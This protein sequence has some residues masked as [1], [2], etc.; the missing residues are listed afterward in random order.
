MDGPSSWQ[1][2]TQRASFA[3]NLTASQ[4]QSYSLGAWI[5]STDWLDMTAYN[6]VPTYTLSGPSPTTSGGPNSTS[7]VPTS[8]S[9]AS[10]NA[11]PDSGSVPPT[12]AVLVSQNGQMNGSFSNITAALA[13][14]PNDNTNQT[15]FIYSGTYTEQVPTINRPGALRILGYTTAAPGSSYQNNTVTITFS[16]GLSVS[17]LPVGHS[18]AETAT[19]QTASNRISWY[20]I[21]MINSD[22]LDGL[23][24]NY[25]TLAA[26]IYGNDIGFYAVSMIGWQDTLLTGATNGYQYYES[27]YIE[28]A[29]DFIWGYSKAYFKGCTIAAKRASSSMT[30]QSRA[31]ASAVGGYIFDQCLFTTAASATVDLTQAV[32]LGRPYSAYAL[33]VVKNSYLDTCI[34]P[35]GWKVWSA[36][37]PRTDHI[38]FAEYANQGPGAWQDNVAARQAFQ[39]CTLLTSDT[40]S[41]ATVMDSTSWIDMTYFNTIVTPAPLAPTTGSGSTV[42]VSGNSTYDGTIPPNGAIIVSQTPING[43]TT[44]NTIQGALNA[45]PASSKTNATIFIYPG[46]YTEHLVVNKSGTTIFQGYS[47]S[48]NNYANNQVTITFSYGVNTQSNESNSDSATVYATGNYFYA[49]NINFR[50]DNGTQQDIASLGFAVKSSKYAL[51]YSCQVYGNQDT[52]LIN[53]FLFA[54]KSYIEGNIDFIWGSGSGYFLNSTIAANED[55]INITADK[56]TTN[57]TQAGFVF[58]QCTIVPAAGK[59]GFTSVGLGRPWNDLARV[60]YIDCYLSSMIE[61]AGWN[62]WSKSTPQ[63]DQVTY[64]EYHNYGPGAAVCGRANFSQQ[65]T[66]SSV[67]QFQLGNFFTTTSWIDYSR[68]DV[69]PF[70]VGIGSAPLPCATVS[71]SS[72]IILPTS[73]SSAST[74]TLSST[75]SSSLPPTTILL[76]KTVTDKETLFTTFTSADITST[77]TSMVTE[78]H[79][80][81]VTPAVMTKTTTDKASTTVFFTTT[82]AAKTS[83]IVSTTVVSM[84]STVTPLPSTIT[85]DEGSTS[86]VTKFSTPKGTCKFMFTE[87]KVRAKLVS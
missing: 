84:V 10:V 50:N 87:T 3:T 18:D 53:G 30:A 64:G 23:E 60:A 65:L 46:S 5:G 13:S 11:H 39:N 19:I 71:S 68:V 25:V 41:L 34:Q 61:A 4:A 52:L 32:Y 40:Y 81:T 20:N 79:G 72:T 67:V 80:S 21:N 26:S 69:Q 78:D 58:D 70:V 83:T 16:R 56:R 17:P 29:I 44:Y 62:Q 59:S 14:L 48:T 27:S 12:G 49:Y 54:F 55:D 86:T 22:N 66:D 8:S 9:T 37:D 45:A 74:S 35:A 75:S 76:T 1:S 7:S 63:T 85:D 42:T 57:T 73:T 43:L 15:V 38:T 51:L 82:V 36:T 33:V 31:S 28:G 77:A 24:S 47:E 2:G 6:Y